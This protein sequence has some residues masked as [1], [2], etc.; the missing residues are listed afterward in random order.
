MNTS[1]ENTDWIGAWVRDARKHWDRSQEALGEA[2]SLTKGNIS[3]WENNRH[4][5]GIEQLTKI[6]ELTGYPLPDR[7]LNLRNMEQLTFI[8]TEAQQVGLSEQALKIARAFDHL[9]KP[10]QRAA[11]IAQ[12]QAFGVL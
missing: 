7:I 11:V 12:L 3:A 5:P 8:N 4:H 9:D 1:T 10:S 2:M 6:S